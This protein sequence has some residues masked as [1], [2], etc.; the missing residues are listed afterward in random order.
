M[1]AWHNSWMVDDGYCGNLTCEIYEGVGIKET[2][3]WY[4]MRPYTHGMV[5]T[6]AM[7]ST[8]DMNED[9]FSGVVMEL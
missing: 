1:Y 5:M 3:Y 7:D 8:C 9:L 4:E 6:N 2:W